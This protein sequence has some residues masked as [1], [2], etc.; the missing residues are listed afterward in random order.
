[1]YDS[2]GA[3][4]KDATGSWKWDLYNSDKINKYITIEP[5]AEG[6]YSRA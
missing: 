3:K 5:L 6:N 2:S 4:I 1:M